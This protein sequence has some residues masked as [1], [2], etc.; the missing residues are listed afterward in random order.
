MAKRKCN[1]TVIFSL[2][3]H[4][5]YNLSLAFGVAYLR[6]VSYFIDA[7]LDK[8][9]GNVSLNTLCIHT[10]IKNFCTMFNPKHSPAHCE[11][12]FQSRLYC[13]Q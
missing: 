11:I 13:N 4:P 3:K 6:S 2:G 12:V 8:T 10:L 7:A 1:F 5:K 9:S